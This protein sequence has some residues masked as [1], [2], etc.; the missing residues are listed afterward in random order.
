MILKRR[1]L[2]SLIRLLLPL[3]QWQLALLPLRNSIFYE[4]S[5]ETRLQSRRSVKILEEFNKE[6]EDTEREREKREVEE[7]SY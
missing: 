2:L 4:Y 5:D 3:F 7:E 6:E 1:P